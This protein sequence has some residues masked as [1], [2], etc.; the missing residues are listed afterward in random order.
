MRHLA[1]VS[2]LGGGVTVPTEPLCDQ[3]IDEL[4]DRYGAVQ[5]TLNGVVAQ[6]QFAQLRCC[7]RC[8]Q[9]SRLACTLPARTLC[10]PCLKAVAAPEGIFRRRGATQRRT[11]LRTQPRAS[12]R[13]THEE[14]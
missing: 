9:R 14:R 5:W 11:P 10:L 3:L 6:V 4:V 2:Y 7:T 8:G 1:Y 12:G 13:A